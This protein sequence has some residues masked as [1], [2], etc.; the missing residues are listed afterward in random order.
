MRQI[1]RLFGAQQAAPLHFAQEWRV[2]VS[3]AHQRFQKVGQL[4]QVG[5][6]RGRLRRGRA[7]WRLEA[8][9]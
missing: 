6:A 9:C 8:F 4:G 5:H 3:E 7:D 1:Q 2:H